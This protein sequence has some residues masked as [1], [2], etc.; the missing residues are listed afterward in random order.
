MSVV[1]ERRIKISS[2]DIST[3]ELYL[4]SI[5]L[6]IVKTRKSGRLENYGDW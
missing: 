4:L 5:I 3:G 6:S 1:N 2:L